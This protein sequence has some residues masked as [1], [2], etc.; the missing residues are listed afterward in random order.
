[1]RKG[2][3]ALCAGVVITATGG[4]AHAD[5]TEWDSWPLG[6]TVETVFVYTVPAVQQVAADSVR[7]N[8]SYADEGGQEPFSMQGPDGKWHDGCTIEVDEPSS[9]M[10]CADGFHEES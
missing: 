3:L 7:W 9:H 1:M 5:T 2:L 6:T 4:A 10:I 8:T